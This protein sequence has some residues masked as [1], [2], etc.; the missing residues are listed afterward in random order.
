MLPSPR[1]NS[2]VN[3]LEVIVKTAIV[4]GL[5]WFVVSYM[6]TVRRVQEEAPELKAADQALKSNNIAGARAQFDKLIA[7]DRKNLDN[8]IT[9][10]IHC[11]QSRRTDLVDAY[12]QQALDAFKNA[13]VADQANIRRALAGAYLD[14]GGKAM[15]Q[16]L[17]LAEKAYD[18]EPKSVESMNSLA[19]TIAETSTDPGRLNQAQNLIFQALTDLNSRTGVADRQYAE[20]VFDDTYAWVL[21][22]QGLY[23]PVAEAPGKFARAADLQIDVI[24]GLPDD[25]EAPTASVFYYH[26]GAIYH[27]TGQIDQARNMLQVALHYD[28][29]NAVAQHELDTLPSE[30]AS[31]SSSQS[32]APVSQ[33]AVPAPPNGAPASQ[34]ST[35]AVSPHGVP[36]FTPLTAPSVLPKMRISH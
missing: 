21:Y 17:P 10:L 33:S 35:S 5:G 19:Y 25:I 20:L 30:E 31:A 8:Y 4:C 1:A 26:M 18:L 3:W 11:G 12:G 36:A 29:A 28:P 6:L 14:C 13:P 34:G 22:K 27:K 2:S 9:I 23:G 24:N 16:A 15:A 7:R 32:A